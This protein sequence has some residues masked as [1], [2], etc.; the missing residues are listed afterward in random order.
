MGSYKEKNMSPTSEHEVGVQNLH[1]SELEVNAKKL[2][3]KIYILPFFWRY[4]LFFG[5]V[6][7]CFS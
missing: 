3:K 7:S 6:C 5:S 1:L 2:A 4:A